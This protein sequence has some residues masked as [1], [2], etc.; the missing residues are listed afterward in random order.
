MVA[1]YYFTLPKSSLRRNLRNKAATLVII[2]AQLVAALSM[3]VV[4]TVQP[5]G[6]APLVGVPAVALAADNVTAMVRST[7]A[8]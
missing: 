6:L 5:A 4:A 7:P 1:R 3:A 8:R 2:T